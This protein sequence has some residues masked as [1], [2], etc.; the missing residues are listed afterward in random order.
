MC[1]PGTQGYSEMDLARM[2]RLVTKA[3]DRLLHWS[4]SVLLRVKNEDRM[5]GH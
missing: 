1:G 2:E 5:Q 3:A 4:K